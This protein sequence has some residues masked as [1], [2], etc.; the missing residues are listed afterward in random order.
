[1]F[2]KRNQTQ[3]P[4]KWLN[5][6][7]ISGFGNNLQIEHS[8]RKIKRKNSYTHD[9]VPHPLCSS[10]SNIPSITLSSMV[11]N[12]GGHGSKQLFTVVMT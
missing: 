5:S 8:E 6:K 9:I 1:M 4:S 12:D 10:S 7:T 11:E 2:W 3:N